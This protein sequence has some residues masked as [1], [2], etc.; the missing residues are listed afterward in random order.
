MYIPGISRR[1]SN[2]SESTYLPG[3]LKMYIQFFWEALAHYYY[4]DSVELQ[5]PPNQ[6]LYLNFEH[7]CLNSIWERLYHI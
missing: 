5:T 1:E 3:F 7:V 6:L 4:Y 2:S